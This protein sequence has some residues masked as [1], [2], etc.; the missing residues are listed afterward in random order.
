MSGNGAGRGRGHEQYWGAR[1]CWRWAIW[2]TSGSRA[3]GK[4]SCSVLRDSVASDDRALRLPYPGGEHVLYTRCVL[5]RVERVPVG[6]APSAVRPRRT[7]RGITATLFL[8]T[9]PAL[10]RGRS[11]QGPGFEGSSSERCLSDSA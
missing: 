11:G 6:N 3:E 7:A 5:D 9:S 1:T 10:N 8:S 2:P 4:D